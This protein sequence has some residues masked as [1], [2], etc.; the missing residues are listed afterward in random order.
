M[1][2][3]FYHMKCIGFC[4]KIGFYVIFLKISVLVIHPQNIVSGEILGFRYSP[5]NPSSAKIHFVDFG[6]NLLQKYSFLNLIFTLVQ[7]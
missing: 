3:K 1:C 7:F 5:R 4:L 6:N 2:I